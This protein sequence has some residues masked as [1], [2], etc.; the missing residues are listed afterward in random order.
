MCY[1]FGTKLFGDNCTNSIVGESPYLHG[2]F[3]EN[4]CFQA[5]PISDW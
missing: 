5:Y 2:G 1:T 3:S 4:F